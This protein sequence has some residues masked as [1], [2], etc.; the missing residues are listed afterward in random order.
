MKRML[1]NR[2]QRKGLHITKEFRW[3]VPLLLLAL[4]AEAPVHAAFTDAIEAAY[5][6]EAVNWA[7][8]QEVLDGVSDP[9]FAPDA[10]CTRAEAVGFLWK[11]S[12][13]PEA[14]GEVNFVD[15]PADSPYY[16]AVRWASETGVTN[17]VSETEFRPDRICTRAEGIAF[18]YRYYGQKAVSGA[19]PFA[20]VSRDDWYYSPVLWG[21]ENAIADGVSAE[22][23]QPEGL[24]TCAHIVTMLWRAETAAPPQPVTGVYLG[25]QDYGTVSDKDTMIHR[26]WYGGAEHSA[27]IPSEQGRYTLQNILEE[28]S[29][30]TLLLRHGVLLDASPAKAAA[31]TEAPGLPVYAIRTEAGGAVVTEASAEPGTYAV[32]G[33]DA[34]YLVP[35]PAEYTPP[36]SGTPGVKTV[37]N[38]LLTALE[39]A[40]T[41]LYI[42]GGGWNWQDNAGSKESAS[43]GVAKSWVQFFNAQDADYH[44]KN[45]DPA[46]SY[47]PFQGWNQ[48]Y[49]AG[50]DCS[51]F[52]GWAIYNTVETTSGGEANVTFASAMAKRMED[53]GLGTCADSLGALRP[54]DVVSLRGHVWISLGTCA[55]GSVLVLHC[56]PGV[57][58]S[59][60]AGGGVQLSAIGPDTGCE[61]YRLAERYMSA[62]WPEWYDRYE[63]YLCAPDVYYASTSHFTWSDSLDPDGCLSMTPAELLQNLFGA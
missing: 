63:I 59:G 24:F 25:V 36:V 1:R 44:Y 11:L 19:L 58:R 15:V 37:R 14:T 47:Y 4:L 12:G 56:T 9:G 26:F 10:P 60:S 50:L 2:T 42:Y 40:G 35:A 3:I 17:G 23:Y 8:Q 49:Y 61:A 41:A 31:L 18:L 6:D 51:G 30:F 28:G 62:Y 13:R 43:L 5:Y 22:A 55:D 53:C 38:F 52:V 29:V 33:S 54:G 39:P 27:S 34:V 21:T 46:H 7:V 20:D 45:T 57:S 32:T 16:D 48:Y